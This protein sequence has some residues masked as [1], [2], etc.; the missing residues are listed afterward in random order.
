MDPYQLLRIYDDELRREAPFFDSEVRLVRAEPVVRLIGPTA[1]AGNN[2]VLYSQLDGA[3]APAVIKRE[4]RYFQAL[5]HSFEWKHHDHDQPPELASLLAASGFQAGEKEE[6][7]AAPLGGLLDDAPP[8]GY[9][10]RE[11]AAD[12][13]LA[14]ILEV[15]QAVWPELQHGWLF[16]SLQR[17]REVRP[18]A[19]FFHAV[20]HAER[21]VCVGWMRLHGRFAALFGGATLTEHRGRGLYRALLAARLQVARQRGATWGLVDAGPMS[22]PILKRL[23][24]ATLTGSTPYVYECGPG[25]LDGKAG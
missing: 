10:V 6:I 24:F 19:I 15:Q 23:G 11:V 5:G 14:S 18:E 22:R 12:A 16:D 20:W 17:E 8:P 21:P 4:I 1:D 2:C 25:A 7:L 13:S 9:S 3:S